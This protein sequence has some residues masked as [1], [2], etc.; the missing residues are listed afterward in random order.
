MSSVVRRLALAVAIAP[1]SVLLPLWL[2]FFLAALLS[3]GRFSGL[4]E[5]VFLSAVIGLPTAYICTIVIGVPTH[6]F[7]RYINAAT[8]ALHSLVGGI[9]GFLVWLLVFDGDVRDLYQPE[10]V[11]PVVFLCVLPA[12]VVAATFGAIAMD[13]TANRGDRN[14]V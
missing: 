2:F 5:F 3:G 4:T 10:N 13:R 14:A 8:I 7:L 6:L 9:G 11:L 12:T 1:L